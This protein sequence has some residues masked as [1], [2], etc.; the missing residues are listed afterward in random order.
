MLNYFFTYSQNAYDALLYSYNSSIGTAKLVAMGGSFGALGGEFS[1][2]S[3]NPAGIGLY[4][5]TEMSITPNFSINNVKSYYTTPI[6][7]EKKNMN[8]SNIGVVYSLPLKNPNWNR[9]NIAIGGNQLASYNKNIMIEGINYTNSFAD[10]ILEFSQGKNI[11]ELDVLFGEPAWQTFLIDTT[12]AGDNGEYILNIN[13]NTKKTQ[14]EIFQSNG[15]KN[16]FS[17]S[18][19]GSMNDNIYIGATIGMPRIRHYSLSKYSEENYEILNSHIQKFDF[20]QES[21]VS[22]TGINIKT[23]ILIRLRESF[24]I[25]LAIHSPTLYNMQ[26]TLNTTLAT[27]TDTATIPFEFSSEYYVLS[28]YEMS[29]PWKGIISASTIFENTLILNIDYEIIDYSSINIVSDNY[30]FIDENNDINNYFEK[31]NNFRIGTEVHLGN[32]LTGLNGLLARSGYARYGSPYKEKEFTTENFSFGIGA[33]WKSGYFTDIAYILSQKQ[34]EHLL[35]SEDY[36]D[37]I[38]IINT[39]H[40]III[41]LGVRY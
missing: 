33:N 37:P 10:K 1:S 40:N 29:T 12:I 25:G 8:I 6:E 31:T 18:V 32:I 41:T 35:Y 15:S 28:E 7:S 16:E 17:I 5:N 22:G 39:D 19:G 14:K 9:F 34:D 30:N 13:S 3:I 36:I 20:H 26:Q 23:G 38:N 24:K 21:L 2:L 11:Q 27:Y 4:Q